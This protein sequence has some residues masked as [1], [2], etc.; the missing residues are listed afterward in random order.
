M[1]MQKETGDSKACEVR[2]IQGT[3]IGNIEPYVPGEN[4]PEYQERLEQFF[5]LNE[6]KEEKRVAMLITLIGPETYRILKSLVLPEVPKSKSYKDLVK[7]LTCH[8]APSVNII[9]ERYKFNQCEQSVSESISDFIVALK[10]CAQS[11]E[12][13]TFLDDALRDRFVC[14]VRDSK[15]GHRD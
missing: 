11:C 5:E 8:F 12:F 2:L 10:M 9:A 14:G 7:A 3:M 4:F 1:V 6:V 13:K 15:Y